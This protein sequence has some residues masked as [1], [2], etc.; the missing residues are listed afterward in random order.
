MVANILLASC[1]VGLASVM[2]KVIPGRD[3]GWLKRRQLQ[4]RREC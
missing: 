4:D 1:T 3:D 2:L